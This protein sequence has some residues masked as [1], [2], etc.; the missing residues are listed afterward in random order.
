MPNGM[1]SCVMAWN[2]PSD[3]IEYFFNIW[4]NIWLNIWD[5]GSLSLLNI[6]IFRE[7]CKSF[8]EHCER[9]KYP[10]CLTIKRMLGMNIA[11]DKPD[12]LANKT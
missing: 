12:L 4:L 5:S 10:T 11:R 3:T 7:V 6:S 8:S 1:D 2:M 9:C